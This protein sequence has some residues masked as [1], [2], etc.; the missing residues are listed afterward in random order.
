MCLPTCTLCYAKISGIMFPI[1]I[2]QDLPVSQVLIR[3]VAVRGYLGDMTVWI[4]N[5]DRPRTDDYQY[6]S[7]AYWTQVYDKH[8]EPSRRTYETLV[9][10][11]PIILRPGE[12]RVL[13]IHSTA[14]HD[15]AIVYDNSYFPNMDRPRYQDSFLTIHTGKAHLSPDVF[16][17]T[18]IWGWG[19]A[20]RSHREF[21]GQLEYGILYQLWQPERHLEFGPHFRDAAHTILACQRRAESPVARLPDECIFYILNMCRYDWFADNAEEMAQLRQGL[22]ATSRGGRSNAFHHRGGTRAPQGGRRE[23]ESS[24]PT[25]GRPFRFGVATLRN[26]LTAAPS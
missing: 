26:L 13:Y 14:P 6:W 16:G 25:H 5:T 21:V 4:S 7:P 3:S 11:Q 17:Q 24:S 8:H 23:A 1:T 22:T 18:P 10:D 15:R 20:W 9:F 19:S 12:E 2:K